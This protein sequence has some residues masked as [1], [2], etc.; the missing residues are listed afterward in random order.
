MLVVYLRL[1]GVAEPGQLPY[2]GEVICD[3][4]LV[5]RGRAPGLE[6]VVGVQVARRRGSREVWGLGR[7]VGEKWY[8]RVRGG[9]DEGLGL[10]R[11]H[12]RFVV[13]GGRL[14]V[15]DGAVVVDLVIV[16]VDAVDVREPRVPAWRHLRSVV[17]VQVLAEEPGP[18]ASILHARGH[19]ICLVAISLVGSPATDGGGRAVS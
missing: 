12:I 18:V 19:V 9:T 7:H 1:L 8:A 11:Y 5:E 3:V 16:I 10:V 14:V 6:A 13:G 4:L 15:L 17:A 2:P